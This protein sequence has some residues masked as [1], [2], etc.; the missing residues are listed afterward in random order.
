[1]GTTPIF[2]GNSRFAHDFQSVID[3]AVT[4]ASLPLQQLNREKAEM[5]DQS[6][7]L[8]GLDAKFAALAKAIEGVQGGATAHS[9]S[10]SDTSV[11]RASVSAD[12][13]DASYTVE[14][15]SLGAFTNSMS[16]DGLTAVSDPS[17][18]SISSSG[19][20]TLTVNG[21]DYTITPASNTLSS[22]VQAINS[23]GAGVRASM[24][25]V[26]P[27]SAPD[28][29][30][31]IQG[32]H[33]NADSIQLNDG[34][35]DLLDTLA[36][37]SPA[38][39]IVNGSTHTI[40]SDSRTVTLAPGVTVQLL[41]SDPGSP[42]TIDITHDTSG[43]HDSLSAL[44][45]AYNATVDE[46][47]KQHGADAGSLA[48]ASIL[49]TLSSALR[50]VATYSTDSGTFTSLADIGL[51]L[52]AKGKLSLDD[53]VFDSASTDNLSAVLSLLGDPSSDGFL[54]LATDSLNYVEDP[55]E[56][57]LPGA[58]DSLNTQ[59]TNQD[60][61]IADNQERIDQLRQGLAAQ[62]AAADAL[63][64]SLEQ[65][66]TYMN[67]LFESMRVNAGNS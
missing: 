14:V 47:D 9:A 4:I 23:A 21:V 57:V 37:G 63:I 42:V 40:E 58:I 54:K 11:L 17:T 67:S 56:G 30:L 35:A 3:R 38:T 29:R 62:M 25:N 26:G 19:S 34:T 59:M 44:V 18:Q 2:S 6:S 8:A 32:T 1:M 41:K 33:L 50:S 24:V 20:F 16:K 31:S 10:V 13:L 66:V 5:T 36:T 52:D 28:Y 46:L 65:Q 49:D 27:P 53:S 39:Y 45:D 22:L 43:L 51:E 12:A 55:I 60:K 64:A 15:T 48:G 61:L 7:V